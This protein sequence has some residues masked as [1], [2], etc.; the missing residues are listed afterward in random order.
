MIC[1]ANSPP[2]KRKRSWGKETPVRASILREKVGQIQVLA[3]KWRFLYI[4]ASAL[5][6]LGIFLRKVKIRMI[7][8]EIFYAL[9]ACI[10]P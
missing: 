6:S 5:K 2:T 9:H 1:V 7:S 4:D 8:G 3:Q 10:A